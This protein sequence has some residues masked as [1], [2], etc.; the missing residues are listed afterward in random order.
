MS[1]TGST[2]QSALDSKT[3]NKS[4]SGFSFVKAVIS[5]SKI[6]VLR[7]I[8]WVLQG[9]GRAAPRSGLDQSNFGILR[10]VILG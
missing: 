7:F 3:Q 10:S 8:T 1:F 5:S 4:L 2:P 6:S 9:G